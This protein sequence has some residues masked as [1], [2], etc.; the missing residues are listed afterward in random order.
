M[1]PYQICLDHSNWSTGPDQQHTELAMVLTLL[2]EGYDPDAEDAYQ[3]CALGACGAARYVLNRLNGR[4]PS[5]PFLRKLNLELN[6][7]AQL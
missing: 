7:L 2:A 6:G 4:F 1:N 5:S 3:P